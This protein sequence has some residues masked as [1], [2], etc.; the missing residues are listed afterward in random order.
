MK[1]VIEKRLDFFER[2]L[3]LKIGLIKKGLDFYVFLHGQF[4]NPLMDY[5]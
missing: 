2:N 1:K 3:F 5:T 4:L